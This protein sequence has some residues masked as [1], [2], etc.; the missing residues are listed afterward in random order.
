MNRRLRALFFLGMYVMSSRDVKSATK[1]N[2]LASALPRFGARALVLAVTLLAGFLLP[3]CSGPTARPEDAPQTAVVQRGNLEVAIDELG[4]VE[5]TRTANIVSPFTGRIVTILESGT[6]VKKGE[7]VAQLDVRDVSDKLEEEI[8]NLQAIKK[9]L[10]AAVENLQIEL[11]SNALD[12]NSANAE[13]DLARVELASVNRNLGD[14]EYLH[15]ENLVEQDKVREAESDLASSQISTF[16]RDMLLRVQV[17]GSQN[18][19]KSGRIDIQRSQLK[20][21]ESLGKIRERQERLDNA[22]IK[23]P[24]DGLFVRHK[25]FNWQQRKSVERQAGEQIEDNDRLGSIPDLS[26]MIVRSQIPE[27]DVKKVAKGAAVKLIF[28]ALGNLEIP[29]TIRLIG[30]IAIERESS[31]GGQIMAAG[32]ALTGEKVFEI[33]IALDAEDARLKP[34]LTTRARILLDSRQNVLIIPVE[35]V[36]TS[37][38]K[39]FVY[40]K[41]AKGFTKREIKLGQ[42]NLRQVEVVEGLNEGDV[43]LLGSPAAATKG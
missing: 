35:A 38:S 37:D 22:T 18:S 36:T 42:S 3:A 13:L 28:E 12:V 7:V 11:R 2:Q 23:A 41:N 6:R 33:E 31:P 30:P 27:S 17:T 20:G 40:T 19:E 5:A 14:L 24:V 26:G 32:Q 21:D 1:W 8:Q 10:E 39:H 16:S 25:R 15:S 4:V 29:A 43:L 9:D 34:G